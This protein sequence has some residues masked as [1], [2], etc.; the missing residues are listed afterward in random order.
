MKKLHINWQDGMKVNQEHFLGMEYA[1]RNE[2]L[3]HTSF[4]LNSYNYGLTPTKGAG[5]SWDLFFKLDQS[6]DIVLNLLACQAITPGGA[7]VDISPEQQHLAEYRIS[8]GQIVE[9]LQ[10]SRDEAIYVVLNLDVYNKKACGE[11]LPGEQSPRQPFTVPTAYLTIAN[12]PEVSHASSNGI[13][14]LIVGRIVQANNQLRLDE[15]YIPPCATVHANSRLSAQFDE[16]AR[17][18]EGRLF[19]NLRNTLARIELVEKEGDHSITFSGSGRKISLTGAVRALTVALMEGLAE[20]APRFPLLKEQPFLFTVAAMKELAWKMNVR[21]LCLNTSNQNDLDNYFAESLG[22][23]NLRG[24]LDKAIAFRYEHDR[25]DLAVQA[26]NAFVELLHT[27]YDADSGLP[28]KNFNW[29]EKEGVI[30][31]EPSRDRPTKT[32][33]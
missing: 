26:C 25:I 22:V 3:D 27:L 6:N 9:R 24:M 18:L 10:S 2:L 30:E 5:P 15:N 32:I 16:W 1:M 28:G 11:T 13:S 21:Y 8:R 29:K 7:F 23:R 14:Q 17:G 20:I 4:R 31:I 19:N 33:D 12:Y